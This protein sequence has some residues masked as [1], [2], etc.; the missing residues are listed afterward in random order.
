[1]MKPKF[2]KWISWAERDKLSDIKYPGV[3][4]LAVSEKD[5]SNTKYK[6]IQ[7]IKY[8]GMTNS[9]G[10]LKSRLKQFDNTIIGKR[11]HGGAKRFLYEYKK[12]KDFA[13]KLF[14]SVCPVVCN[15]KS[16]NPKD[17]LLMGEIA[18]REYYCFAQ[19][20]KKY[21]KLPKFNDKKLSPKK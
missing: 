7:E 20:A 4:A 9:G 15:V 19:Y 11:G 1:M 5:L 17:L 16:N 18:W 8:F 13:Q 10:G 6:L 12:H 3:Y 2:S 14:V 21:N